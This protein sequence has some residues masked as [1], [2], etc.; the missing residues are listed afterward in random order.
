MNTLIHRLIH[1]H[2]HRHTHKHIYTDTH[3]HTHIQ[4][5]KHVVTVS[6]MIHTCTHTC[7]YTLKQTQILIVINTPIYSCILSNTYTY[8]HA[9]AHTN[10]LYS[11]LSVWAPLHV[12]WSSVL[13]LFC[14]CILDM[15]Y[16]M[17]ISPHSV[18]CKSHNPVT[19]KMTPLQVSQHFSCYN[20]FICSSRKSASGAW[21][22]PPAVTTCPEFFR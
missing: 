22:L 13:C 9:C 21:G 19:H 8:T 4:T 3:I 6:C 15:H 7:L 11:F 2:S 18:T 20:S 14:A 16:V 12:A 5:H 17:C 1:T 10:T